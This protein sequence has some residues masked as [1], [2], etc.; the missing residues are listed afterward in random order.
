M[1]LLTE[2]FNPL[3]YIYNSNLALLAVGL[4]SS[5]WIFTLHSVFRKKNAVIFF[6]VAVAIFAVGLSPFVNLL[7]KPSLSTTEKMSLEIKSDKFTKL[8]SDKTGTKIEA[9]SNLLGAVVS[10]DEAVLKDAKVEYIIYTPS[11]ESFNIK[12]VKAKTLKNPPKGVLLYKVVYDG[13]KTT[14]ASVDKITEN[15]K[16]NIIESD[17]SSIKE[18]TANPVKPVIYIFF[19]VFLVLSYTLQLKPYL[20]TR[21]RKPKTL[22]TKL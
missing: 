8:V 10:N 9:N 5:L 12:K 22:V 7:D 16:G 1:F 21:K 20:S 17:I 3:S 13:D 19:L 14:L 11:K 6:C 2:F 18:G 15:I 4:V